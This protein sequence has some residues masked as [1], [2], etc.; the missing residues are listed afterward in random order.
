[1]SGSPI[2]LGGRLAGAFSYSFQASDPF[3]GLFTPIEYMLRDL[4]QTAAVPSSRTVAIAP[5]RVAG[6][7]IRHITVAASPR[8]VARPA[9]GTLVAVP[10]DD[11]AVSVGARRRASRASLAQLLE[12]MGV[13]PMAGGSSAA[14]PPSIPLEPGSAIGVALLRGDI[15]G[16]RDRHAD[17]SRR[18]PAGGLRPSVHGPG[19]GELRADERDDLTDGARAVAEHQ[20]RRGRLGRRH[21]HGGPSGGGRRHVGVLPRL[22]GVV[23]RV[24]DAE[25]GDVP[26]I[27]VSGGA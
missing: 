2:Y 15:G 13:E 26:P 23:V 4:P 25:T 1:M 5:L 12:P 8:A 10:A 20:G 3:I 9:P 21:D 27:R 6:Q 7:V 24:T 22:F 14:L 17:V 11:A 18:Q 16:V 19:A